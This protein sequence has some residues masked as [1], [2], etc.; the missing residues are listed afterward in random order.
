MTKPPLHTSDLRARCAT[1]A[2]STGEVAPI[3]LSPAIRTR[4]YSAPRPVCSVASMTLE[5]QARVLERVRAMFSHAYDSYLLHALPHADLFPL[6]CSGGTF[7]LI[8]VL[9]RPPRHHIPPPSNVSPLQIPMVTLIDSLDTLAVM[10]NYSEFRRAVGIVD[11]YFP[12]F[13]LDVNVS[14]FE[15]TIRI[16]GGLLSAHLLAVDPLL[17]VYPPPGSEGAY[18]G[19]LLDLAEDLGERLLPAFKTRTGAEN[20]S[21]GSR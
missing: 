15:T 19:R 20:R 13:S 17:A 10:G 4:S 21:L 2:I 5:S 8:K 16:L 1:E 6:S 11:A 9:A 14:V 3:A 18:S 12:D 7:D